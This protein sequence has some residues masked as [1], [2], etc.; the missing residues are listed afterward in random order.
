MH[1][2]LVANRKM[3]W[4]IASHSIRTLDLGCWKRS[5]Y[6]LS[7]NHCLILPILIARF[8]S[9]SQRKIKNYKMNGWDLNCGSLL[10]ETTALPTMPLPY[11]GTMI[12]CYLQWWSGAWSHSSNSY[13][14]QSIPFRINFI[15]VRAASYL[16]VG[17]YQCDQIGQFIALLGTFQSLR[18]QLF[19]PN[20]P[21]S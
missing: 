20:C 17:T 9:L 2:P 16:C 7:H 5:M 12:E 6:Q 14:S 18:Q 8:M 4:S 19:C 3:R 10:L 11:L 15:Y 1:C 21:H 13:Q